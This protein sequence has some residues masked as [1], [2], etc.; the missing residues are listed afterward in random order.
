M[1][2]EVNMLQNEPFFPICRF[3][4]AENELSDLENLTTF[5][6]LLKW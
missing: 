3:D 6:I 5:E 2:I 4:G 1:D